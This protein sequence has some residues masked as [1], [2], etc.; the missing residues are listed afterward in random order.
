MDYVEVS[1]VVRQGDNVFLPEAWI[2]RKFRC[3]LTGE[4]LELTKDN[5]R[6]KAFLSFGES[7]ID[8]GDGYYSRA[9]GSF[10]E[11]TE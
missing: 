9:G 8:L 1:E 4:V 11:I 6:P 3:K 2:G 10:E 5:V 7:Y